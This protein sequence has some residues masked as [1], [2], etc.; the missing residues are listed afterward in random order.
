MYTQGSYSANNQNIMSVLNPK[1]ITED[2]QK[3]AIV[4]MGLA[5]CQAKCLYCSICA[6]HCGK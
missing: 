3:E 4:T 5:A 2:K 1:R 6:E